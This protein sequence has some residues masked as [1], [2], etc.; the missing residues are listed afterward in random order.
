[1][2]APRATVERSIMAVMLDLY[3]KS[4]PNGRLLPMAYSDTSKNSAPI[5]SPCYS[6]LAESVPGEIHDQMSER[7]VT[8][9]LIPRFLTFEVHGDRPLHNELAG[10][11]LP[12][13]HLALLWQKWIFEI[14]KSRLS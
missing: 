12:P 7:Q 3:S 8:N 9:G 10:E 1:M 2:V 13:K 4:G 14:H 5:N 6:I 11:A